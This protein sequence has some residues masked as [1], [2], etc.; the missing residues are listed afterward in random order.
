MQHPSSL[1]RT[2][3][4]IALLSI[5]QENSTIVDR[6]STT[7]RLY[8]ARTS[9]GIGFTLTMAL[10]SKTSRDH[11][12]GHSTVPF[13]PKEEDAMVQAH[14]P[15][16]DSVICQEVTSL[17]SCT[18]AYTISVGLCVILKKLSG[19]ERSFIQDL[20]DIPPII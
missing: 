5:R 4:D 13:T 11:Q 7:T 10:S 12:A 8:P 17:A 15:S 19:S 2:N 16:V 6:P 1:C 14:A 3:H 18:L 20:S 9:Q